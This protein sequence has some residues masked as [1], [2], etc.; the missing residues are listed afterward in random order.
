M[1][2]WAGSI[3]QVEVRF[4]G[5]DGFEL[6]YD[7]SGTGP[8]VVLLHGWPG[9]RTDFR[10]LVPMLAGCEVVLPDL[11]GFGASD[12]HAADPAEQYNG[13]AQARSIAGLI[14]ELGLE[15]PVVVGYDIGSRIAQ[16]LAGQRPDLV[17]AL[18]ITPPVPGVGTR[19]FGPGPLREF[20]YQAFHRLPLSLELI[21]GNP[22]AVRTYLRHFWEHWS[23]PGYLVDEGALDH[24][25]SVYSPPGA[26]TASVQWYRAGGGTTTMAAAET[27]PAPEDRIAAPAVVLWPEQDP[28]FPIEWSDRIDEFFAQATLRPVA[29]AGHFAPVEFPGVIAEEVLA[30]LS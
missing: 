14:T 24:L 7:R 22:E 17:R 13:Q 25:V 10:Y 12:K 4:V 11:R 8:A 20:W 18:V 16:S 9:D 5:V 21:D 15:R 1:R 28:L 19:V 3:G 30:F 26:F 29:G 6:A 27:A 2:V 23:G